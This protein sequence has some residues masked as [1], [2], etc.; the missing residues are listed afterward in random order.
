MNPGEKVRNSNHINIVISDLDGTLLDSSSNIRK[1]DIQILHQLQQR[2]IYTVIATGR[3]F[4]SLKK[5]LPMDFPLDYLI[6]SC[7]AGIMEWK[8]KKIIFSSQMSSQQVAEV[9]HK[10]ISM[11]LDFMVQYPIPEN[12]K[13]CFYHTGRE[14][15]DF[16]NRIKLYQEFAE[17]ISDNLEEFGPASQIIVITSDGEHT[18]SKIKK[19]IEQICVIRTTSP[20]DHKTHWIELLSP[21]I[22]KAYAAQWL[23]NRLG[24]SEL[25]SLAVGNDYNDLNLLKWANISFVMENA[26]E[27][28]K[29]NFTVTKSNDKSGFSKA[30]KQIVKM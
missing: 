12:H 20:L 7:G 26:P 24:V 22:S 19:N 8:S 28:I 2:G 6:F 14:N 29:N 3:S 16:F 1:D 23:C 30:V 18:V 4:F 17:P 27:E 13:F 25:Q 9:G 10:L 11:D 21:G 15:P 5:V